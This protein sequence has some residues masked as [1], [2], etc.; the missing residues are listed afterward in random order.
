MTFDE[1]NRYELPL[2]K[3]A[4]YRCTC[5]GAAD[6]DSFYGG[7]AYAHR[8][9]YAIRCRMPRCER[10]NVRMGDWMDT[11]ADAIR[12]WNRRCRGIEVE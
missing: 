10:H 2:L 3:D 4:T 1:A 9:H 12:A 8:N 6:M 5:G 11:P 7:P